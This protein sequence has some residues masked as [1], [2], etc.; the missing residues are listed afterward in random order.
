MRKVI[1]ADHAGFCFGVSRAVAKA[2]EL[3]ENKGQ[4]KTF[5]EL[6]HNR[7]VANRLKAE[8]VHVITESEEIKS[9]DT[10]LVR[11]HGIGE[12][13]LRDIKNR[14]DQV[15]DLTCPYVAN[16]HHKVAQY[17]KLGYGI[18]ILGDASHPEVIGINGWCQGQAQI[19]PAGRVDFKVPSKVCAVAQ[20]TEKQANWENLLKNLAGQTKEL[21]AFNTICSATEER[22]A[23]T[24]KL[25]QEVDAMVVIGG[26]HSS[27]TT[28]LFE[29]SRF[30]CANTFFV[31]NAAELR[32]YIDQLEQFETI[33]ITAGASTPDW[34]IKEAMELL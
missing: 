19:S 16:I 9:E 20:T 27:N 22:Q 2:F 30:H 34:I 10:V 8:G 17:H 18:V 15:V 24:A 7:D 1:L 5:G 14:S 11:S 21:V 23:A 29:I 32:P 12:D 28:K 6:I 3:A 33:G 31:E 13:T 4:I 26:K 25:A